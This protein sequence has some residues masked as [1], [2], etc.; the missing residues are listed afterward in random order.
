MLPELC[1][2][3][4]EDR[5][6]DLVKIVLC[7]RLVQLSGCQFGF[8]KL[9]DLFDHA[10]HRIAVSALAGNVYVF[11]RGSHGVW[12]SSP[13]ATY[14]TP[15]G[16][17]GATACDL[18]RQN[19]NLLVIGGGGS[20]GEVRFARFTTV[21]NP[22]TTIPTPSG[23]SYFGIDAQVDGSHVAVAGI[24]STSRIAQL[25]ETTINTTTNTF[26]TPMLQLAHATG[27]SSA[28]TIADPDKVPHVAIT[29]DDAN[30]DVMVLGYPLAN[31]GTG[32]IASAP[33]AIQPSVNNVCPACSKRGRS[34]A[35][36][37]SA[38]IAG[39]YS[40][41]SGALFS[42]VF[43][44]P[45]L[46]QGLN[47]QGFRE[48]VY[49]S[50]HEDAGAWFSPPPSDGLRHPLVI[51]NHGGV[52]ACPDGEND[53]LIL[54]VT[55]QM[56]AYKS[57]G[58][59]VVAPRYRRNFGGYDGVNTP[60]TCPITHFTVGTPVPSTWGGCVGEVSDALELLDV[61]VGRGQAEG[62]LDTSK[63]FMVGFSRGGCVSERAVE[64]GAHVNAAVISAAVHDWSLG[65]PFPGVTDDPAS[66]TAQ[67]DERNPSTFIR[68]LAIANFTGG[69]GGAG[70]V[71][72]LLT[73]SMDDGP[74]GRGIIPPDGTCQD[75][76]SMDTIVGVMTKW[77]VTSS[78]GGPGPATLT[79]NAGPPASPLACA[80]LTN[81]QSP[82][83]TTFNA[84]SVTTFG[85]SPSGLG[86]ATRVFL[87][88]LNI[89]HADAEGQNYA[90]FFGTS[91]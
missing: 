63:I 57:L 65:V 9:L 10:R 32:E 67:I 25:F 89:G 75:V 20:T 39:G 16:H 50:E 78:A 36:D 61:A 14:V 22:P 74:A 40:S 47:A 11:R 34:L 69:L 79:V 91:P 76:A 73:H 30:G 90:R 31:G 37:G 66:S 41:L 52:L 53:P 15:T 27:A 28:P 45:W 58:Y 3:G 49:Q 83:P 62:W 4:L 85:S 86:T 64:R 87:A 71:R 56:N 6:I 81:W 26:T 24:G 59:A 18:D 19:K 60:P 17:P 54:G 68:Q 77:N 84:S 12:S 1:E 55:N 7:E 21:W 43:E 72:V 5:F 2:L 29:R 35:T 48:I 42:S 70:Q 82:P 51:I 8:L 13:E 33:A 23:I 46:D 44:R 88:P 38:V 80:G